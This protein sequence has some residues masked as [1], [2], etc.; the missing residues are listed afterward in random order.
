MLGNQIALNVRNWITLQTSTQLNGHNQIA[1]NA[2]ESKL[3]WMWKWKNTPNM[4]TTS[5]SLCCCRVEIHISNF[6]IGR[7]PVQGKGWWGHS[8]L[9]LFHSAHSPASS[10]SN[11]STGSEIAKPLLIYMILA[12]PMPM[13]GLARDWLHTS[14]CIECWGIKLHWMCTIESHSTAGES[15]ALNAKESD[16]HLQTTSS[17][18]GANYDEAH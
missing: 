12:N 11:I 5:W 9:N 8:W 1:L 10:M 18:A 3:Q 14:N 7:S 2:G 13:L 4:H 15:H 17:R 16:S 6:M